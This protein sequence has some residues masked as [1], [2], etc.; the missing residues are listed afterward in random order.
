LSLSLSDFSRDLNINTVSAYAAA[1]EAKTAFDSLPQSAARTF[2]YTGNI[3]N[4]SPMAQFVTLGVGK[5][6]SAHVLQIAS[7]AY[8][9]KG[10]K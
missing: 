10:Y 2:I 7:E 6:A 1:I 8:K 4:V 9:E 3:L 5:T